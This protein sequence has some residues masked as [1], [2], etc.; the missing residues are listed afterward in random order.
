MASDIVGEFP[1]GI[2][3]PE[4]IVRV[5]S[6]AEPAE[7]LIATELKVI[8]LASMEV[9]A[10]MEPSR[11]SIPPLALN[12]GVPDLVKEPAT[13]KVPDAFGAVNVPPEIVK[14]PFT[15]KVTAPAVQVPSA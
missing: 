2:V 10:A 15:S 5:R 12:V 1:K 3:V 6:P 8:P 11:V 13:V 14:F 9:L 4:T 7:R